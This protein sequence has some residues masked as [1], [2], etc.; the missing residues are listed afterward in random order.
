VPDY[1]SYVGNTTLACFG[2]QFVKQ[3]KSSG[4]LRNYNNMVSD[5]LLKKVQT[6][7]LI[8]RAVIVC[9]HCY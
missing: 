6:I 3:S 4:D 9:I 7:V 5:L 2:M 8:F 1:F